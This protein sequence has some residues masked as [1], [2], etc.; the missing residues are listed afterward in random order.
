MVK[1]DG[2][3]K[4]GTEVNWARNL[5]LKIMILSSNMILDLL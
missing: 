5:S 3:R 2:R 4:A 1:L